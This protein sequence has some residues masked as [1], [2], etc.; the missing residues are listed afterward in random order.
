MNKDFISAVKKGSD[1]DLKVSL[2][3]TFRSHAVALAANKSAITGKVIDIDEFI[4]KND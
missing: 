1:K 3:K 4:S 2:E